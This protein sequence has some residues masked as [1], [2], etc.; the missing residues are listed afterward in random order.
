MWHF[1]TDNLT[2]MP[3]NKQLEVVGGRYSTHIHTVI[4]CTPHYILFK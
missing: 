2:E 3:N 4:Y 1:A